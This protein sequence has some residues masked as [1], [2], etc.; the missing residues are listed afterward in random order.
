VY[1]F[2]K[3][4]FEQRIAEMPPTF[5]EELAALRRKV[6]VA[7]SVSWIRSGLGRVKQALKMGAQAA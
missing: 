7:R 5:A 1:D 3:R 4:L 6:T 2:A